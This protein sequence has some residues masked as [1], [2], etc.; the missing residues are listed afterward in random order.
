MKNISV[1]DINK[2]V[3]EIIDCLQGKADMKK[4]NIKVKLSGFN[5]QSED[6]Q[7]LVKSDIKRI[8]QILLNLYSNAIKFT[9]QSG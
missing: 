3:Y 4:I 9:N 6:L 5:D 1:F 7:Y 2:A 8:Q